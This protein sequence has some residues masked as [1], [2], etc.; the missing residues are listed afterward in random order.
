MRSSVLDVEELDESEDL[1]DSA[2]G[3]LQADEAQWPTLLLQK[4]LRSDQR[5]H[6]GRIHERDIGAVDDQVVAA[7]SGERLPETGVAPARGSG[8]ADTTYEPS[9]LHAWAGR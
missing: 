4:V 8:P 6:S 2:G 5:V 1:D 3:W 9:V 7:A